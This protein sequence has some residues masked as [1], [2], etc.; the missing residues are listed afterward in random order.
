MQEVDSLALFM[1]NYSINKDNILNGKSINSNEIKGVVEYKLFKDEKV[2]E[3]V[4][5]IVKKKG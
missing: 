5:F 2:S 3:N 1:V 4:V